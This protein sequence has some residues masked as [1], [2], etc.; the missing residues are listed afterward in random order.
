MYSKKLRSFSKYKA[1]AA[2]VSIV[3]FSPIQVV[4][5]DAQAVTGSGINCNGSCAYFALG[6]ING[7]YVN[8]S[9]ATSLNTLGSSATDVGNALAPTTV[10]G[11][12][13]TISSGVGGTSLSTTGVTSISSVISA[14]TS[15]PAVKISGQN[16]STAPGTA[17]GTYPLIPSGT[18]VLITGA[19]NA[20]GP[21]V[22]IASQDGRAAISVTN[23]GV[24]IISPS[25]TGSGGGVINVSSTNNYGVAGNYNTGTVNN[26]FGNGNSTS[27]GQIN[28]IIGSSAAGG[29]AV[30]NSF[31]GGN[32]TSTN[33]VGSVS[34]GGTSTNNFGT[35]GTSGNSGTATNNIGTG[36]G[37][38]QN[39]LGNTNSSSTFSANAGNS[40][41][42]MANGVATT[43]AT[44]IGGPSSSSLAGATQAPSGT[45]GIVMSG[46]I[47]TQAV[48]DANGKITLQTGTA[49][50]SSAAMTITNGI[51]NTHGIVVNEQQATISGGTTSS[52]MTLND[53]GATFSNSSN[54]R[55]IQVHGVADG[56][57]NFDAVNVQQ[58]NA[59]KQGIAGVAAMNNIPA[60][61]PDKQFNIGV[62]VGGFDGQTSFALGANARITENLT[63]KASVGHA[64]NS[65]NSNIN[66]TTWGVGAA[67]AW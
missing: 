19:G 12:S 65:N 36:A 53:N 50:Q 3:F 11:S 44:A 37:A 17:V 32:G 66:D 18:G 59:V 58:L 8:T 49:T 38:S 61:S 7:I 20:G 39:N 33:S 28:N 62:G 21:D 27:T 51:G 47:G 52:S 40:T 13:S 23:T 25:G 1:I 5:A 46:A 15:S 48:V 30:N 34:G 60:L 16:G 9:N 54:G 43:G 45:N 57:S 56:T 4:A 35:T 14:G 6:Q 24:Q 42:N 26:N 31:G 41:L 2:A 55:P 64:F 63:A 22:Y 10:T 67:L 29:G